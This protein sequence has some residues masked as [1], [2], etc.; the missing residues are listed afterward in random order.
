MAR[1]RIRGAT[2]SLVALAGGAVLAGCAGQ[3]QVGTP[4]H[5]V[6]TWVSGTGA[7]SSI[8][9]V[10]ADLRNVDLSLA[11]HDPTGAIR[12]VCAL[13]ASDA[14]IGNGNLPTPDQALTDDLSNAYATAYDAGND[15]YNG[16]GGNASLMAKS[17]ALRAK[18]VA[19]LATAIARISVV[20]GHV[21]STTTTTAPVSSDPFA[22]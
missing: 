22:G 4:A 9:T 21:P 2:L 18:T 15:C 5:Q 14:A 19:Q 20:T 6:S 8:G 7:G 17:A 16:S 10:E 11:R 1:R 12:S 13:L 3:E